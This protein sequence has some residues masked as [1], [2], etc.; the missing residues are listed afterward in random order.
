MDLIFYCQLPSSV[1]T[2]NLGS[3]FH[4]MDKNLQFFLAWSWCLEPKNRKKYFSTFWPQPPKMF[5]RYFPKVYL[6][7]RNVFFKV[8]FF[9]SVFIDSVF[10]QN[11]PNLHVFQAL[12]VYFSDLRQRI[13]KTSSCH[14]SSVICRNNVIWPNLN[15]EDSLCA[16][17][18]KNRFCNG[19][20]AH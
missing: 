12:R 8:Y 16:K 3:Q 7:F 17:C 5:F 19:A 13:R 18:K 10:L 9:Q 15:F 14:C 6:F 4:H 1:E 20:F 11:V 2:N